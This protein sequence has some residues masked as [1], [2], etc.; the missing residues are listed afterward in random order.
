MREMEL[1]RKLYDVSVKL[2]EN[3]AKRNK[4]ISF[5]ESCT[6]GLAASSIVDV[7]G[8]SE[9]FKGGIVAYTPEAKEKWLGVS[10]KTM[11]KY[12][13]VSAATAKEMA[14]GALLKS[15]ADYAISFTGLAGSRNNETCPAKPR[16]PKNKKEAKLMRMKNPDVFKPVGLV[17]VAV[18]RK[19]KKKIF[20]VELN[21][22]G[23]RNTIRKKAT[24]CGLYILYRLSLNKA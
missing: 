6:G 14:K 19:N 7:D 21:L 1:D 10:P 24:L 11:K 13:L 5:A 16:M 23:S 9:V 18:A 12:G 3:L 17:Y 8:A 20:T 22:T 2:V 4:K 15:D